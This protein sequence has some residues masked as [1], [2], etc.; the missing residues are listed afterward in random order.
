MIRKFQKV[1]L[2]NNNSKI[3]IGVFQKSKINYFVHYMEAFKK[4]VILYYV[5]FH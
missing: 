3:D 5:W 2:G 1:D 4:G